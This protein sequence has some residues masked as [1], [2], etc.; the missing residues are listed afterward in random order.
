MKLR[1]ALDKA[2]QDKDGIQSAAPTKTPMDG[3]ARN[4]AGNDWK[5]P[6]YHASRSVALNPALLEENRCVC[7]FPDS[8]AINYFKMLRTRIQQAL[9]A[10]N[11]NTVMITSANPGEGKTLTA[12]NLA[13]TF[14]RTFNQTVLLIDCDLE[15]QSIHDYLGIPARTGLIDHLCDGQPLQDIIM[16]PGI[17]KMTLI[18]GGKTRS[19]SAELLSSPKMKSLVAEMKMRYSDRIIL[20]DTPPVLSKADAVAFAPLVDCILMI[21]EE[22]KT[23]LQDVKKAAAL[24]PP[25]KFLGF[26]LNKREYAPDKM[27]N[28][29]YP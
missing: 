22:G 29:P 14:T 9:T 18:S 15:K 23:S 5:P 6:N 3:T 21:V 1:K 8:P 16:W 26:V 12:I 4:I 17:D 25:E 10:N 28:S 13:L 2:K 7:L 19:D 27:H 20:F 11:W 24:L